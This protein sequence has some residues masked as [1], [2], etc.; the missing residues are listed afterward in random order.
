[1][2]IL[3]QAAARKL[4]IE[5]KIIMDFFASGYKAT[6]ELTDKKIMNDEKVRDNDYLV[7]DEFESDPQ[8]F[9]AYYYH[10]K[11]YK[12]LRNIYVKP[13]CRGTG[14]G[15]ELV[16]FFQSGLE[17]DSADFLQ[18]GV[19]FTNKETYP[20]LET[21]YTSLGFVRDQY[22]VQISPTKSYHSFYWSDKPFEVVLRSGF[23]AAVLL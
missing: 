9:I 15:S 3:K 1:M 11:M 13:E 22:P 7:N 12:V 4:A 19:E 20:R 14:V 8:Y 21:W 10:N 6:M 18:V 17:Q 16:R 5:N 2:K 23:S